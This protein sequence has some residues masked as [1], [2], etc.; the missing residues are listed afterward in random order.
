MEFP[1]RAPGGCPTVRFPET[2]ITLRDQSVHTFTQSDCFKLRRI[3]DSLH[4]SKKRSDPESISILRGP[5]N[6][7]V[8]SSLTRNSR[9]TPDGKI[10]LRIF[11]CPTVCFLIYPKFFI[12][13]IPPSVFCRRYLWTGPKMD[14][15]SSWI[16][17][18]NWFC[19]GTK[20]VSTVLASGSK[21]FIHS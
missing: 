10:F 17:V 6:I 8:N 2:V 7:F 12:F 3:R 5:S 16:P 18:E 4:L 13:L 19:C 20:L 1:R 14:R 15:R 9:P 11:G 21:D